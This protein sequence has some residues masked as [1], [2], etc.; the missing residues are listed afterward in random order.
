ML[1]LLAGLAL[2]ACGDDGEDESSSLD[3]RGGETAPAETQPA[4][5]AAPEGCEQV[6]APEPKQDGG[7]SK[8]KDELDPGRTYTAKVKTNCGTFEFE[9][10][11][12]SAPKSTASVVFLAE[13]GFYD[14]TVFHRI[15]PDFV[16]QGGDPTGSGMGGPGYKTRDKPPGNTKYTKGVVAMAKGGT[17][18][19]GTAGSQFFVV[20]GPGGAQLTPD[21]AVIGEITKGQKVVDRIGAL[22]GP[23]EQPVAVVVIEKFTVADS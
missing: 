21:Y 9:L 8:P 12:E 4:A 14:G 17:E 7:Q 6:D 19:A 5:E 23:D 15:V 10:D 18:P 11:V 1:M 13:E 3:P 20:T 2:A 16:I 22:G